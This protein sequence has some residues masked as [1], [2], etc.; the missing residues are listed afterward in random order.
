MAEKR[1]QIFVDSKVQ[2]MLMTRS[3]A[4]WFFCLLTLTLMLF[5]WE[6]ATGPARPFYDHLSALWRHYAPAA[7]ASLLLLPIVLIDS[8]R[9]SNRFAGPMVRLRRGLSHLA[10]GRRVEPIRLREGDAWQSLADEFNRLADRV[11]AAQQGTCNVE[12]ELQEDQGAPEIGCVES[13]V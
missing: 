5:C 10:D 9:M 1:R 4:Y 2:G 7:F 6:V 3:I 8:V 13:A 12:L 11:Q